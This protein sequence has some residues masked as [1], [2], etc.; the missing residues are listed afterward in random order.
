[1]TQE[2]LDYS[3]Y[4]LITKGKDISEKSKIERISYKD[5][6]NLAETV[7]WSANPMWKYSLFKNTKD[8]D[9]YFYNKLHASIY[10]INNV[11]YFLESSYDFYMFNRW[12]RNKYTELLAQNKFSK[13]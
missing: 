12:I 7:E 9:E 2:D 10:K 8:E 3:V 5:L 1:M 13:Y 6:I 4:R 11:Y